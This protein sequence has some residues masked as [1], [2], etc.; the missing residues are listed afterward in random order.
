M[1]GKKERESEEKMYHAKNWRVKRQQW[2][3]RSNKDEGV[4]D[5]KA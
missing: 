2:I 5:E 1:G 3:R 4:H